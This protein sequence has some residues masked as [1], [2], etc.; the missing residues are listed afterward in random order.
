MSFKSLI[1][2]LLQLARDQV[3]KLDDLAVRYGIQLADGLLDTFEN[4]IENKI[5]APIPI[6]FSIEQLFEDKLV[7]LSNK[8]QNK[9]AQRVSA[10]AQE[11]GERRAERLAEERS[12]S[13]RHEAELARIK[14]E[15]RDTL[16]G[17][18]ELASRITFSTII[19]FF[20]PDEIIEVPLP[21]LGQVKEVERTPDPYEKEFRGDLLNEL[22]NGFYG[23]I[24]N[25]GATIED[26]KLL[27]NSRYRVENVPDIQFLY[28]ENRIRIKVK[29]NRRDKEPEIDA[30]NRPWIGNT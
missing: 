7:A 1:A 6:D 24:S 22:Q 29:T 26:I 14:Q 13:A 8:A 19:K 15:Y 27:T 9:I 20:P 30:R 28:S 18:D 2:R 23:S 3:F 4:R 17:I 10:K 25:Q 12:R 16:E 5:G 21:N 11:I